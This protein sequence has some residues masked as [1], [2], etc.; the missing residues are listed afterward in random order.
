MVVDPKGKSVRTPRMTFLYYLEWL[1]QFLANAFDRFRDGPG[2]ES[3][4][5]IPKGAQHKRRNYPKLTQLVF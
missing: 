3:V 5:L 1:H 4:E 2:T